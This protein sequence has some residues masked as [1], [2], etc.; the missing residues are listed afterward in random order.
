MSAQPVSAPLA[1]AALDQLF[2]EARSYNAWLDRDV[3]DEQIHAIWDLMKMGPT[4]ANQLPA[5]LVWCKS[6]EAKER[7]AAHASPGCSTLNTASAYRSQFA[8][9]A[10]RCRRPRSVNR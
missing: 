10:R 4:S 3:S 8:V 9:S 1:D 7:L 6:P 5:R 2:R